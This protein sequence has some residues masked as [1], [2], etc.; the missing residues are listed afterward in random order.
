[1]TSDRRFE[2]TVS[3]DDLMK[4]PEKELLTM[5]YIQAV[6][7]NGTVAQSCK[8][9]AELQTDMKDKIGWKLFRNF[10]IILTT[11]IAIIT[12]LSLIIDKV[13]K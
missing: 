2:D 6:Q 8:D 12:I 4:K 5:I 9:I 11:L 13:I 10:G 7:T 1:V 3:V